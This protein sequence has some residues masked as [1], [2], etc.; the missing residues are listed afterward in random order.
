[1]RFVGLPVTDS[2]QAFARNEFGLASYQVGAIAFIH[3]ERLVRWRE[4]GMLCVGDEFNVSDSTWDHVPILH[5]H[6]EM[7]KFNAVPNSTPYT[8]YG[9]VTAFLPPE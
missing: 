2:R 1:M 9:A 4:L 6:D 5:S 8:C 3:P 7:V